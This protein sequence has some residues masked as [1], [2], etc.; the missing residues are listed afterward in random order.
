MLATTTTKIIVGD[1]CLSVEHRVNSTRICGYGAKFPKICQ[2]R[3]RLCVFK[4][5]GEI[6]SYLNFI[7]ILWDDGDGKSAGIP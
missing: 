4:Q 5:E 6:Y 2:D 7:D 3:N 1:S